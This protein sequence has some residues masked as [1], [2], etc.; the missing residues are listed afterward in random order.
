MHLSYHVS[1]TFTENLF[2]LTYPSSDNFIIQ[3]DSLLY[4][5]RGRGHTTLGIRHM[6]P[7]NPWD[8][9]LQGSVLL[10]SNPGPESVPCA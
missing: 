6:P 10:L 9:I 4:I 1:N 8:G 5:E 2:F 3:A 7:P